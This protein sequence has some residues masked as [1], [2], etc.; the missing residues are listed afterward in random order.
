MV[1]I[2]SVN[3]T[4]AGLAANAIMI[5]AMAFPA[6]AADL[7]SRVTPTPVFTQPAGY[8]VTIGVG[9]NF[10]NR[11][12]GSKEVAVFPS[13]HFGYRKAGE[14]DPFFAPDDAVSVAVYH[15]PYFAIGPAGNYSYDR[16]NG[17]GFNGLH[18]IGA[19]LSVGGFVEVYPLPGHLRIRGEV[20]KGVT[21]ARGL[22]G[23]LGADG[24]QRFGAFELS[25]GP[26]LVFGDN[27]YASQYFSVTPFE[28]NANGLLTPYQARGGLT[29]A[30]FM[31]T[32]RYDIS[33]RYSVLAFGGYSR[34][35]DS[36]GRSPIPN[37]IGDVNQ[38]NAGGQIAYKFN[39]GGIGIMGY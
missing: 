8:D 15:N 1:Q 33:P 28:A 38:F 6:L 21:G 12:P 27:R 24:I 18:T 5:P 7:P 36:V 26:R 16:G 13:F 23:N 4:I 22:I 9:P 37:R 19:T 31:G 10:A 29:Q 35:V 32:V 3:G 25:L 39:F 2:S 20:L 14:P 11:F 17:H 30:G 34:L